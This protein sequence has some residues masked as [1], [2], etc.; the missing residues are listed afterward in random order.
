METVL[1]DALAFMR[2]GFNETNQLNGLLIALAATI[3]MSSWRQILV[4]PLV[5]VVLHVAIDTLIPVFAGGAAF[6]LPALLE[7]PFWQMAGARYVGYLIVIAVFFAVKRVIFR[8]APAPAAA[9]HK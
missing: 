2:Y 4:M 5:A 7:A 8:A 1:N 9:K 3:F 6:K